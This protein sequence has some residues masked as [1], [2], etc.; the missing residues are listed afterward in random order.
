MK[1]TLED[2]KSH[3]LKKAIKHI[4]ISPRLINAIDDYLPYR[5]TK[6]GY[7]DYLIIMSKG[8]YIGTP[9][10][11]RGELVYNHCRTIP[12]RANL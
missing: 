11:D 9:P 6:P 3:K 4:I 12:I 10:N 5:K 2:T 7:E 1:L 8:R